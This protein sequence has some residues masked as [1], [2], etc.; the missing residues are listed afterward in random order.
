MPNRV[1]Q[2]FLIFDN[3][4]TVMFSPERQSALVS[5]ITN[6]GLTHSGT[7]WLI[8]VPVPIWQQWVLNC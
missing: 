7:G 4:G 6:A 8:A 3:P 5:K 2:S 1:K